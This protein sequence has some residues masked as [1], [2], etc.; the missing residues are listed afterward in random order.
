[1]D[2]AGQRT[3]S[4]VSQRGHAD[5]AA[6]ARLCRMPVI[7]ARIPGVAVPD[8]AGRLHGDGVGVAAEHG[9]QATPKWPCPADSP[10][11]T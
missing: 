2:H 4:P 11:W 3:G 8:H 10:A 7:S 6:D 1:M 9:A 5:A